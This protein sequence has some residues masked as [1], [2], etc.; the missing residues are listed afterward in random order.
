MGSAL[1]ISGGLPVLVKLM[2]ELCRVLLDNIEVGLAQVV[3][4]VGFSA[5]VVL[6]LNGDA[7]SF[8]A[9]G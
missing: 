1:L 8:M 9:C 3:F 7:G 4:Q 2:D 5:L 6:K